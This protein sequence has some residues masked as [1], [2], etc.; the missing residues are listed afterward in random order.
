M[1]ALKPRSAARSVVF[2]GKGFLGAALVA[3]LVRAGER[4][5]VIDQPHRFEDEAEPRSNAHTESIPASSPSD[6]AVLCALRAGDRLFYLWSNGDL[7]IRAED[8]V[9]QFRR[10][11]L[12][13]TEVLAAAAKAGVQRVVFAS[14]GGAIYGPGLLNRFREEDAVHTI[15]P[16]GLV[17][18]ALEQLLSVFYAQTCLSYTVLR[19]A[20][21][22]G[23]GALY[24]RRQNLIANLC[25]CAE[26]G[27]P[28]TVWGD[29]SSVRDYVYVEDVVNAFLL[30]AQAEA[31]STIFNIG[32]GRGESV[33]A[34]IGM[35]EQCVGSR[36]ALT[37]QES[38]SCDVSR[39]ILD[40]G[41]ALRELGWAARMPLES[42]IFRTWRWTLSGGHTLKANRGQECLTLETGA[43]G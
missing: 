20:N 3:A 39:S 17:K 28:F 40:P 36:I 2:G 42:G 23:P 4:V 21:A 30:A 27:D 11:V 38:R 7:N 6:P 8:A 31:G 33:L 22:Y 16:Y 29:G 26:Q 32:T 18:V 37:F 13:V 19:I 1:L 10:F 15:N 35:V 14:S 24:S 25:R 41:K 9:Q 5:L 43:C 12:P 34:I